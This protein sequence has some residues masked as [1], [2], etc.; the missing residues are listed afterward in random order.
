MVYFRTRKWMSVVAITVLISACDDNDSSSGSDMEESLSEQLANQLNSASG[1]TGIES[2]I[3]PDSDDFENIPQ[4][5]SN[6]LTAEK[7]ALGRALYHETALATN[8]V[9][10]SLA[11]TWSCASCHHVAAGFKSGVI[12]G[13]AEGGEGFGVAGEARV[14]ALGFDKDST[15]PTLVPDVQPVTSPSVLNTAYQEVMLW[16]G[17]FG[18]VIGGNVNIGLADNILATPD[19]PKAENSRQLAGLEIQAIAG[20]GV[21]RLNVEQNSVLQTNTEYQALFES[22][23]PGGSGDVLEDAGKAIAAY[24]RTIL[25]SESP[26]QLWLKGDESALNEQQ[27]EGALLFFGDA[28]CSDCHRGPALSSEVGASENEVFMAIGFA[29]FDPNH[30][31]VTGSVDDATS[32]GRGGFT[33]EESDNFKFKVPQLYNLTDTE[34]FG[35]GG[36]FTSVRDVIAYKNAGI[37]QKVLPEG[38]IDDRFQP[39]GLSESQLDALAAFIEE[40][41]YDPNLDRYV[42]ES[43][44]SGNCFPVNDSVSQLELDCL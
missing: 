33:G 6:P 5:P 20:L 42:P 22:A 31:G 30:P 44:P 7:V 2:L 37:S 19:T 23:Y 8:G 40:G 43:I 24:E 41:L 10:D 29:D 21:H 25:A 34:V 35:H 16:N 12:Q 27:L 3:F 15:D 11:G 9:N 17:Q 18:N 1:G 32:R 39:L 4:D 14:L 38:I 13:V 28:G 36:S 26:F